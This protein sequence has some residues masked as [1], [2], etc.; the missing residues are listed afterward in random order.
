VGDLVLI[1]SDRKK[2]G[3]NRKLLSKFSRIVYRV[4]ERLDAF[5]VKLVNIAT[6]VPIGGYVN[7]CR[8]KKFFVKKLQDLAVEEDYVVSRIR[9]EREV[10]GVKQYL[11]EWEGYTDRRSTWEKESNISAPELVLGWRRSILDGIVKHGETLPER[12]KGKKLPQKVPIMQ[13]GDG[14]RREGEA[15][16][17][18]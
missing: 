7:V 18:K 17:D 13:G 11:V 12:E 1:K 10:D 2:K 15:M 4:V 6:R 9:A 16:R 3:L 14:R 5:R 8:L